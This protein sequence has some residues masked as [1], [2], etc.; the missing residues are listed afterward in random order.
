METKPKKKII[1]L[2]SLALITNLMQLLP[3]S[4][5]YG[6]QM[7]PGI[8]WVCFSLVSQR[9]KLQLQ[10]DVEGIPLSAQISEDHSRAQRDLDK[11]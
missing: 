5:R 10:G 1:P 11:S 3:C 8:C 7:I 2:H 9:A 4:S 6:D